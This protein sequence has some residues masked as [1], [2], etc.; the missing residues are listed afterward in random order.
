MFIYLSKKIA[1]PNGVKLCSLGWN[2]SEGWIACGGENGLL[3]VLKLENA[4]QPG[5]DG[6]PASSLSMNQTLEGH[7]GGVQVVNWNEQYKKLTSSDG[8]GLIIVWMLHKG[9]WFEEMINNR[10]KSTV[11]DQKWTAD[12][13]KI[14]IVY[15]DGAIIVGSVDGNRLWG[16]ELDMKGGEMRLVAWA[17]D[18][19]RIVFIDD[20]NEVMLFDK[21]GNK[22]GS[23]TMHVLQGSNDTEAIGIDWYDGRE[24]YIEPD[25][26][27]LAIGFS[28]GLVQIMRSEEDEAP[29]LIDTGLRATQLKWNTM[30]S[31]LAISGSQTVRQPDGKERTLSMV[32]FY[33]PFGQHLRTLKVPSPSGQ[34]INALTWEGSSLR[35]ALAVDSFIYFANIRQDYKWGYFSNTLVYGFTKADRP[36]HCVIFWDSKTGDKYTKY[37]RKLMGI[38]AAGENC[39]LSK[40]DDSGSQFILILCNAIGSPADSKYIDVEPVHMAMTQTHVIVASHDVIY[41]WQ[42]RTMVSKLTSV[43]EGTGL[44]RQVGRERIFHVDDATLSAETTDMSQFK[45]P[46]QET[47]DP[48]CCMA[49]SSTVLIVGRQSGVALRYTLPHI[50]L[51]GRYQLR[52]RPQRM[53]LNCDS[54]RLAIIDINGILTFF[55]LEAGGGS[56][57]PRGERMPFERKDVWDMKWSDDNPE[58]FGMMEKARL[59]IMRGL[60]PEEPV[61]SSGCLCSF[62]DLM[63]E[64]AQIDEIMKNPDHPDIELMTTYETKS[65]RDTR[66]LLRD[67]D[68][69]AAFQF[70]ED[71]PHPRLWRLIGEAALEGLDFGV[72]EQAFVACEDYQGIQFVKRLQQLDD[73][74][75]RK[76]EVAANFKRFDEAEAIYREIDRKD[77]AIELRMRLGDW[78][79][80]VQLVQSGAGDDQ[81]LTTAWNKIGDYYA[82]R[83]K[84]YKAVQYYQQARNT[85]K[86]IECNYCL[87]DYEGMEEL[88][89]TLPEGDE[90]LLDMGQKFSSVGMSDQAVASYLRGGEVKLAIETCVQLNQWDRAVEL[91]EEHNY[92]AI[93]GLLS[94][95]ATHLLSEGKTVQAIN[96]YR[97]ANRHTDTAKLLIK[98]AQ[99]SKAKHAEPDFIKKIY[100]LAALEMDAYRAETFNMQMGQ[101]TKGGMT[102]V[103]Q[104]QQTLNNL[105]EHDA[106]TTE[107][108]KDLE[109]GWRG[110]EAYHLFMLAQRQLYQ[111]QSDP[112]GRFDTCMR[113]ALRLT[114]YE[115]ILDPAEVQSL[116]ALTAYYNGYF[117]QCSRAFTKLE[118][119]EST[120]DKVEEYGELA[121]DI[122]TANTTDDPGILADVAREKDWCVATG[123]SISPDQRYLKCK[124]CKRK[125]LERGVRSLRNCPLCHTPISSVAG[126]VDG[127]MYVD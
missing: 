13:Q 6:K 19:K 23:I 3:K 14:C 10:N 12:G 25:C 92:P 43:S 107:S 109:I 5:P 64:S 41:V 15:R 55:D 48:I 36:E 56:G 66:D 104:T 47:T 62:N 100:V 1:I 18:S 58:L 8:N 114:N 2:T 57:G 93:E 70:V 88:I 42:Y 65:L 96:L 74:K 69:K 81:L 75:K 103:D 17:P 82:E 91:A 101:P 87:D 67:V 105:M 33:S 51:E 34:G 117:Q 21:E 73:P 72:A 124:T 98:L 11:A 116:I 61:Q 94:K 46:N 31:V 35:I 85:A 59:Y 108:S 119:M 120:A 79:R 63:I 86:L 52:C 112:Q 126:A 106:A 71:N 38:R 113:T 60:D 7:N 32:Q 40:A 76:A 68:V 4:A 44:R 102:T 115:D 99:E 49:A 111:A 80:V 22:I 53:E 110:A 89:E 9:M 45:K 20:R 39:V 123:K 78:F 121:M 83:K 125:C 16:K 90:L 37:V 29:V 50:S 54:T 28:N 127:G 118:T 122:F 84:W 97:K 27:T 95:Y 30:G 26:P 24:G 77:L